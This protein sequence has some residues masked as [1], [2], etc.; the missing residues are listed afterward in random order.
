ML[1]SLLNPCTHIFKVGFRD[2]R[3]SR[4][5]AT[6]Q[7]IAADFAIFHALTGFGCVGLT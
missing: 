2:P 3:N 4:V 1:N 7:G 5:E 6:R